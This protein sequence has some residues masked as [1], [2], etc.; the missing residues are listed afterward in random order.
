MILSLRVLVAEREVLS[1]LIIHLNQV[2]R[3]STKTIVNTAF[4]LNLVKLSKN[5]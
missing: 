1:P 5:E 3:K 2:E 4:C